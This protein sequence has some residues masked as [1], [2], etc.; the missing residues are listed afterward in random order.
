MSEEAKSATIHIKQFLR[1]GSDFRKIPLTAIWSTQEI[2][3]EPNQIYG[4]VVGSGGSVLAR[5]ERRTSITDNERSRLLAE[6]NGMYWVQSP[7]MSVPVPCGY[8]VNEFSDWL[9]AELIEALAKNMSSIEHKK[10]WPEKFFCWKPVT[11]EPGQQYGLDIT[12][13]QKVIA[14]LWLRKPEGLEEALADGKFEGSLN[15]QAIVVREPLLFPVLLAKYL[16]LKHPPEI[17]EAAYRELQWKCGEVLLPDGEQ[18]VF[19]G[20]TFVYKTAGV[21]LKGQEV[22]GEIAIHHGETPKDKKVIAGSGRGAVAVESKRLVPPVP[23][24]KY[25]PHH[26]RL[27]PKEVA[28]KLRLAKPADVT[29]GALASSVDKIFFGGGRSGGS[30]R[31]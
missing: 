4:V 28:A 2:P 30:T 25:L 20:N 5:V 7:L 17:P 8:F 13:Q 26:E 15:D 1:T 19:A 3:N 18:A 23:L 31:A 16:Q 11:E 14:E 29:S 10:R 9:G 27:L 22:V 12:P 21:L 6:E 24:A